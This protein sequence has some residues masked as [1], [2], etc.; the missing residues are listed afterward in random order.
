MCVGGGVHGAGRVRS[1][2]EQRVCSVSDERGSGGMVSG[3]KAM[4]L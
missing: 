3:S 1:E 4:M 2:M